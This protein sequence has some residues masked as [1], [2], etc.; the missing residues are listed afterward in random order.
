MG[1]YHKSYPQVNE[2][3]ADDVAGVTVPISGNIAA[4]VGTGDFPDAPTV[5]TLESALTTHAR[6]AGDYVVVL[7]GHSE[8]IID[9]T[10]FASVV[11]GV[12]IIGE[13]DPR[14]DS[15][16][17]FK[18]TNA[19][20][21]FTLDQKNLTITNVRIEAGANNITEMIE[22]T[23]ASCMVNRC[24]ILGASAAG[25]DAVKVIEFSSGASYVRFNDNYILTI[26]GGSNLSVISTSAVVK[27]IDIKRNMFFC[28]SQAVGSG[29][30]QI[31]QAC[32]E[33]HI[34]E[35]Y[36]DNR[37]A[38]GTACIS[39]SDV[40]ATGLCTHNYMQVRND[41]VATVQGIVLAGTT[42]ILVGFIENY[43]TDEKGKS[44]VLTPAAV[45]T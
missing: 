5:S 29:V 27:R 43:V 32:E 28:D 11:A 9:A 34:S 30:I 15:C 41:G 6:T 31:T 35:N 45:A 42:N 10:P 14:Q 1:G 20:G 25:T 13:G 33:L 17:T 39:F 3:Q 24:F 7:N 19:A 26:G 36:I 16:G 8:N 18:F 2:L 23:A 22:I 37:L 21:K 38:A 44:G 4:Y 12:T 40:A